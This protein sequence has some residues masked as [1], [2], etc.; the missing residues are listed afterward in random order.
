MEKN[1]QWRSKVQEIFQVC[2]NELKKTTMIGKRMISASK[3]N[4]SL[5]DAFKDL[6]KLTI[7][8]LDK[9]ELSWEST[10]VKKL[11]KAINSY[12]KDLEDIEGEVNNIKTSSQSR[13]TE[14]KNKKEEV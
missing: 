3:T 4:S 5:N 9:G 2:Q 1:A 14:K 7:E 12:K 8:A 10:K 13:S 11:V 6:G